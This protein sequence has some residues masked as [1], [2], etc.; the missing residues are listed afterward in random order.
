MNREQETYEDIIRY[1]KCV[2][3][4]SFY[5]LTKEELEEIYNHL[6]THKDAIIEGNKVGLVL[7]IE[8]DEEFT[9]KIINNNLNIAG[10][11]R[12]NNMPDIEGTLG[13]YKVENKKF[14]GTFDIYDGYS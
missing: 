8:S 6:E 1:K 2:D 3:L 14:P 13:G 5:E 9:P 12:F 7:K 4:S 10:T 11:G